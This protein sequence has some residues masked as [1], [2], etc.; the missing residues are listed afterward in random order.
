VCAAT[1]QATIQGTPCPAREEDAASWYRVLCEQ[2]V[3]TRAAALPPK[4]PPRTQ[5]RGAPPELAWPLLY[6]AFTFTVV[7]ERGAL[8]ERRS[9]AAPAP[10]NRAGAA[11]TAAVAQCD[12]AC[13]GDTSARVNNGVAA[14][15]RRGSRT[16]AERS[17]KET[18]NAIP[19][20]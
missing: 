18:L 6:S 5:M 2:T 1:L 17:E 8:E 12:I 10:A 7:R 13:D 4:P 16:V 3:R 14:T 20:P 15:E 11:V 9:W 19:K